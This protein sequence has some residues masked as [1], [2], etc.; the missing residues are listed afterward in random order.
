M[1]VDELDYELPERLIAQHP[2]YPRDYARLMVVDKKNRFFSHHKF[3]EIEE[4]INSGDILVLN[5]SKV[6]RARFRGYKE[7]T[8]GKREVFLLKFIDG[9]RW[10]ALTSPNCRVKADDLIVLKETPE[11]K[12]K[13]IEKSANGENIVEFLLPRK[14]R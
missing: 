13:V 6:I 14:L 12:V 8:K 10:H 1:K 11:I 3:Y 2:I 7:G 4:F 5:N 9:F